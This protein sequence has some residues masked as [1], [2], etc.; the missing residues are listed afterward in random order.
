MVLII[1]EVHVFFSGLLMS[2]WYSV[3]VI[4]SVTD[5]KLNSFINSKCVK[6]IVYCLDMIMTVSLL[7]LILRAIF[8]PK[9]KFWVLSMMARHGI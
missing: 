8:R 1:V 9:L 4:V 3:I 2:V 7:S 5:L 6:F